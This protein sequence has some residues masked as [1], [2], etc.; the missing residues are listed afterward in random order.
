MSLYCFGKVVP[1][2]ARSALEKC[3]ADDNSAYLYL[4]DIDPED[5]STI[6]EFD[7]LKPVGITFRYVSS[8]DHSDATTLWLAASEVA[9]RFSEAERNLLNIDYVDAIKATALGGFVWNLLN[10]TEVKHG[11]LA[12][13]DGGVETMLQVSSDECWRHFLKIIPQPWD[14]QDNPLFIWSH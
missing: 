5:L 3:V 9:A 12:L 6:C 7:E 8:V 13:V 4:C 2:G 10:C 11:A 14:C 1:G